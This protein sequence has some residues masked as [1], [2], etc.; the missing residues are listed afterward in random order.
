MGL[1]KEAR[2]FVVSTAVL[3]LVW[4]LLTGGFRGQESIMGVGAAVV[5]SLLFLLVRR[6]SGN[7]FCP[8]AKEL[9]EAWRIPW[10]VLTGSWQV[11]VVLMRDLLGI[12]RAGSHF[13]SV[14][15]EDRGESKVRQQT[16]AALATAYTSITPSSI[17]IGV[18]RKRG[19]L[20]FH[21]LRREKVSIMTKNLGA[22]P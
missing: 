6:C 20:L 8:T 14:A 12:E 9:A 15:F 1:L 5:S 7:I 21:E 19:Q 10:Y 18:D 4:A 16:R 3:F 11:T 2:A 17:V 22:R 13:R